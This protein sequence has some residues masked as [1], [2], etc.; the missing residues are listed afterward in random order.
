MNFDLYIPKK[1][2]GIS[3]MIWELAADSPRNWQMLPE[4]LISLTF[5]LNGPWKLHSDL[6]TEKS[7]NPTEKLAFICGL[8]TKP[9]KVSF[10]D[11]TIMG[12]SMYP[13]AA[14]LLFGI[15]CS[16]LVN[17]AVSTAD[18]LPEHMSMIE[19]KIQEL[20]DFTSRAKWLEDFV[21]S[22]LQNHSDLSIAVKISQ[23]LDHITHQRVL[24]DTVDLY[25]LT[26]YSRM[27]TYRLFK[28]WMGLSPSQA[29]S[30]RQFTHTLENMH[31]NEETITQ[32]ALSN[33]YYD[34]SHFIRTFKQ[35]A[36]M[37]PLQYLK[38]KTEI[39]GQ[40]PF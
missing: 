28:D 25:S 23:L 40:L 19:N 15:P 11:V 20:P 29:I 16:E 24:G 30:M 39:V 26:G 6:F 21:Y 37:T 8:Q 34:Q 14:K 38:N 10:S 36:E 13:I 4:G 35:F 27:H 17:W 3:P 32:I 9:I 2:E 33:G 22:I 12:V 7:Y 18:M 1:L 5:K 31:Y